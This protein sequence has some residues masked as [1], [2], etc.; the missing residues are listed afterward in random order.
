MKEERNIKK[1]KNWD[2]CPYPHQCLLGSL[3]S[4]LNRTKISQLLALAGLIL[5]LSPYSLLLSSHL[6]KS[7]KDSRQNHLKST[8][9]EQ[10]WGNNHIFAQWRKEKKVEILVCLVIWWWQIF[11]SKSLESNN[12]SETLLCLPYIGSLLFQL[13][14]YFFSIHRNCL[15]RITLSHVR[16]TSSTYLQSSAILCPYI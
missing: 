3:W 7:E 8:S 12:S 5:F 13:I 9:W 1:I 11:A 4:T 14:R 10:G 16:V 15:S 6:K 2:P